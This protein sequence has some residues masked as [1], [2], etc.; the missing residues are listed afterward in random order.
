VERVQK[1][2]AWDQFCRQHQITSEEGKTNWQSKSGF[3]VAE[4]IVA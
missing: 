1:E 3:T 4:A 2:I